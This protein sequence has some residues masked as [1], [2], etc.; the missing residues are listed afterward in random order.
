MTA[1]IHPAHAIPF[2]ELWDG[3]LEAHAKGFVYRRTDPVT[4]LQI[5]AYSPRCVYEDGWDTHT[6]VARGLI[7]DPDAKRIAATPFPKFFNAGERRGDIPDLPFE[8]FEKLDGSLIILFHHDGAWR[9]AT[10]GSFDSEQARWAAGRIPPGLRPGITYLAEAIYPENR[11]VVR[12]REA[13]LVLLAAYDEAGHELSYDAILETAAAVGWRAASRHSF[14][15]VHELMRHTAG[16]PRDTEGYV[17]RF[18]NGLRLNLKGAEYCRVHALIS[19][20]TPLAI[21]E[22]LNAGGDPEAM[23]RELPEEF[24]GDFDAI[25]RLLRGQEDAIRTRVAETAASVAHL[26]DKEVGLALGTIPADIRPYL[27]GYRKSGTIDA[28]TRPVLMRAIRPTGNALPGYTASYAM[29]RM[30]EA[31]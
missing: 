27:F 18:S 3:L 5:F 1:P 10:K 28:R 25:V 11:M 23:R 20:C 26:T 6:M 4:R 8:A 29:G 24:W 9:T 17:V 21:W 16:L 31:E 12:Y 30:M 19:R 2:D 14:A 15:S 7:L 13:A 22:I